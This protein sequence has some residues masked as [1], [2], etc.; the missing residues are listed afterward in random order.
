MIAVSEV[1]VKGR[2]EKLLVSLGHIIKEAEDKVYVVFQ[3]GMK[4]F[5]KEEY[6]K[7]MQK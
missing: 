6:Q 3:D 4:V 5:S 7:T 2:T 1:V